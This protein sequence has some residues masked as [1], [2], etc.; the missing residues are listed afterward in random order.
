MSSNFVEVN[1]L[2]YW[3]DSTADIP[4]EK[5]KLTKNAPAIQ[6]NEIL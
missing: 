4:R 3:E 6:S 5:K 2:S 1:L